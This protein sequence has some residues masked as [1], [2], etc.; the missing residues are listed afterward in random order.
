ML[1][2][3]SLLFTSLGGSEVVARMQHPRALEPGE[4]VRFRID[5]ARVHLFDRQTE[6]SLLK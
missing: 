1:G 4:A 2:D 5:G 6:N 3:Q